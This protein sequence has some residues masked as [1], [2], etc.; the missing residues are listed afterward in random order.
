MVENVDHA[1]DA[2]PALPIPG[3][4][5][6]GG[7][8]RRMG[9]GDKCLRQLAGRSI[10]D[11]VIARLRPQLADLAVN[12]N[13]D[14][15]RFAAFGLPVIADSIPGHAGPLAGILAALDWA[16]GRDSSSTH[17]LVA[18]ADT[19]FLPLDLVAR[20]ATAIHGRGGCALAASA[21]RLH[22]V[23]GLWPVSCRGALRH[24]ITDEG[25]RK[26]EDWSGRIGAMAVAFEGKAPDPFFNVNSPADLEAAAV[27]LN[28]DQPI[29]P[30]A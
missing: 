14:P 19:P 13:G 7:L 6:A 12:A 2:I 29:A 1:R 16:A 27:F 23:V 5:L 8:S 15:A 21:G 10:L 11:H 20:L 24:A 17:V 9:G 3:V 28:A 4:I 18:P 30:G 22:P 25:L 26:V